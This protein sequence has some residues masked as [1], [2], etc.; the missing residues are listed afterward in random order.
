MVMVHLMP[1][2]GKVLGNHEVIY[3]RHRSQLER[4]SLRVQTR[5][6]TSIKINNESNN[7]L[8]ETENH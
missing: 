5:D 7:P 1:A 3:E 6:N 2:S 8:K 4:F